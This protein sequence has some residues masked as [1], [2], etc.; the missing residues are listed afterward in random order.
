M[1]IFCFL[2]L[3]LSACGNP[4]KQTKQLHANTLLTAPIDSVKVVHVTDTIYVDR[5]I[6][7]S[8]IVALRKVA[9]ENYL[10][11]KHSDYKVQRVKYYMR[12]VSKNPTQAKYLR[13][14]IS[15]A[16]N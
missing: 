1:R 2:C 5:C 8:Q 13:S 7:S 15:R 16:V 6:D 3:Y 9:N 10:K 12:I 14:W 4:N 11:Y